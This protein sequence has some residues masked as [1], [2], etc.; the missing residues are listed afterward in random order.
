MFSSRYIAIVFL[1]AIFFFVGAFGL[2][3]SFSADASMHSNMIDC[4]FMKHMTPLVCTMNG[5]EHFA[6]WKQLFLSAP[7]S[8]SFFL[9]TALSILAFSIFVWFNPFLLHFVFQPRKE[10]P[11]IDFARH[12]RLV[13][14]RK[15]EHPQLY[16]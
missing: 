3:L 16:A 6:K 11:D 14:L 7:Y 12:R 8:G 15:R 10:N 5:S 4:P 1:T 2:K 13:S 9:T